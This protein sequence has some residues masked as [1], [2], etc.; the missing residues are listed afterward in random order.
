M[1]YCWFEQQNIKPLIPFGFG[2]SYTTFEYSNLKMTK[3]TDGNIQM[4]S[5]TV[6]NTG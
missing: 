2:L 6:T 3:G 5:F 4:I 1:G